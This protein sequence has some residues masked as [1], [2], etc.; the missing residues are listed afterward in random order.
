MII[1]GIDRKKMENSEQV[2]KV[3]RIVKHRLYNTGGPATNDIALLQ[4]SHKARV[5]PF[6]NTVC[7]PKQ[8][9]EVTEGTKCYISG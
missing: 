7:L 2:F 5:T 3:K 1:G 4:L 9:E 6:V 8:G